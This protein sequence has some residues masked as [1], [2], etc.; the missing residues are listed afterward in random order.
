MMALNSFMPIFQQVS[1]FSAQEVLALYLSSGLIS[2]FGSHFLNVVQRKAVGS[3]GASGALFGLLAGCYHVYPQMQVQL[4]VFPF[5][6]E[7]L[8]PLLVLFDIAGLV[9]RFKTIDHAGHLA[10]AAVGF[11]YMNYGQ[12]FYLQAI[13]YFK[14]NLV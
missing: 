13:Q 6:L 10:G 9:F 2:S 8:F 3:L 5:T 1:M 14:N 12:N 4:L 11:L 7:Q